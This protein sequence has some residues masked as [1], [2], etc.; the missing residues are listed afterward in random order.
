MTTLGTT[1]APLLAQAQPAAGGPFMGPGGGG[2]SAPLLPHDVRGLVPYTPPLWMMVAAGAGLAV[3]LLVAVWGFWYWRRRRQHAV[4]AAPSVWSVLQERLH[5][6]K[7]PVTTTGRATEEFFYQVSLLL[8]EGLELRTGIRATDLTTQELR[9]ALRD[10]P[11]LGATEAGQMM[12]FFARAD[13][14][15]FAEEPAADGEAQQSQRQASLWLSQLQADAAALTTTTT[16]PPAE[17]A[18]FEVG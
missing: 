1:A 18:S 2:A 11:S 8:R 16:P 10:V 5:A 12:Q 17:R 3:L 9:Q 14:I 4:A 15:K 6:L 13:M 7:P